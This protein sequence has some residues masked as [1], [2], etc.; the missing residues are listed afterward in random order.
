MTTL[1]DEIRRK[2]ADELFELTAHALTRSTQRGIFLDEL[3]EAVGSGDVIENYPHDRY[4]PSCLLLGYTK[5][6]R[7]L[8]I[9][10]SYPSRPL[11]KIITIY[12]PT[13]D[14]WETNLK[15]RKR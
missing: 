5:S 8:H 3:I 9:Q 11:L 13:P 15:T 14:Q 6:G 10:L 4:G 12:E 7:A 2:V 1:I